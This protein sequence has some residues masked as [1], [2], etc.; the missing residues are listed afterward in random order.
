MSQSAAPDSSSKMGDTEL[1]AM[2]DKELRKIFSSQA[3]IAGNP[4]DYYDPKTR[5]SAASA[6]ADVAR[7]LIE[8]DRFKPEV[9]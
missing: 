1:H 6:A 3:Y 8:L 9:K 2:L 4:D 5:I 7:A